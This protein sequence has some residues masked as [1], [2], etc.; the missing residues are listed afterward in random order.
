MIVELMGGSI[1]LESKEG[2]GSI[3]IIKLKMKVARSE[4]QTMLCS[5]NANDQLKRAMTIISSNSQYYNQ[6]QGMRKL[7]IY[8][9][10]FSVRLLKG[11]VDPSFFIKAVNDP[12]ALF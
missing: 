1:S 11:Y 3:F 4:Y 2:K 9:D 10:T 5:S 6:N 12:K 7:V 8:S